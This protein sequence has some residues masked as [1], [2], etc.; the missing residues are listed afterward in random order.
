MAEWQE[1]YPVEYSAASDENID[2]W[3]QKYISEISRLYLLLNRVRRNDSKA[4]EPD[5]TTPY[6][7]HVDNITD[8]LYMRN[9]ADTAWV[10]I[11]K[12]NST[13]DR[14]IFDRVVENN[15]GIAS[16]QIGLLAN[17]PTTEVDNAVYMATNVTVG[18]DGKATSG[19]K[20][21]YDA[22]L[23]VWK[24]LDMVLYADADGKIIGNLKGNADTASHAETAAQA[25]YA[26]T[27]Q[28]AEVSVT[29]E[30]LKTPV[31]I[32]GISF[33][34]SQSIN[35]GIGGSDPGTT[36]AY[37]QLLWRTAQ[38]EREISNVELAL[39]DDSIFP[40]YNNLLV[41]NFKSGA[42]ET[43][44]LTIAVT[45]IAAGDNSLDV[46]DLSQI[47]QGM[48]LT[49]T[50]GAQQE[51]VQIASLIKSG[52]INRVMLVS[53]T[54]NTYASLPALYRTTASIKSDG[55]EGT[56]TSRFYKHQSGTVW[57]GITASKPSTV[58][59]DTSQSNSTSFSLT[60][61]IQFT[62]DS[63]ITLAPATVTGIALISSGGGSGTWVNY[64]GSAQ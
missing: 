6:Q 17:R 9:P 7:F 61:S 3:V 27:A 39:A 26:A 53:N 2:S 15:G 57:S 5:D 14:F 11:G 59:L 58:Q 30:R 46:A 32:N 41:E 18:T 25:A 38:N 35:I 4:G 8:I 21:R 54:A 44:L 47:R 10:P 28:Q 60:S 24:E 52:S 55:A 12:L 31:K 51:Y 19:R 64:E 22:T 34:G 56:G 23:Q 62:S 36:D 40:D 45:S 16:L 37:Q 33:D 20:Y 43:D 42:V 63:L 48:I 29:T 49:L 50:D 13:K 1:K